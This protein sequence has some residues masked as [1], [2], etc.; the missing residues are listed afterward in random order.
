MIG[1][2]ELAKQI[3]EEVLARCLAFDAPRKD[4]DSALGRSHSQ[5]SR[6]ELILTNLQDEV[7]HNIRQKGSDEYYHYTEPA[8]IVRHKCP[9]LQNPQNL[10][11]YTLTPLVQI[12]MKEIIG[13]ITS[14]LHTRWSREHAVEPDA[15]IMDL[16]RYLSQWMSEN[17]SEDEL[18]RYCRRCF[19]TQDRE[20]VREFLLKQIHSACLPPRWEFEF[21]EESGIVTLRAFWG[22]YHGQKRKY[23]IGARKAKDMVWTIGDGPATCCRYVV[24][25]D[26]IF[27]VNVDGKILAIVNYDGSHIFA[28]K[29]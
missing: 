29:C 23:D 2:D 16:S 17:I 27:M 24:D 13:K 28:E 6:L 11:P 7:R 12:W 5:Q 9:P 22:R 14:G 19:W 20:G 3:Q 4:T 21:H 25:D 18:H 8:G 26:S 1:P 15:A 10:L